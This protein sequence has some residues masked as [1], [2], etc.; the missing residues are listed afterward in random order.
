MV[1]A[2]LPPAQYYAH[3]AITRYFDHVQSRPPIR[4]AAEALAPA[5]A[6]VAFDLEHAPAQERKPEP[7]KEKKAKKQKKG[8]ESPVVGE[9]A[10]PWIKGHRVLTETDGAIVISERAS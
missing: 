9:D 2:Q 6:L 8:L 5:F 3:P 10:A 7:P 1:Q 4:K